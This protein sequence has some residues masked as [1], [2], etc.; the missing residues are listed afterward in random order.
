MTTKTKQLT[1][2]VTFHI[3]PTHIEAWKEAHRPVWDLCAQEP[4]CLFF[5]VF[6]DGSRPGRFRLV[7]VWSKDREWFESVQLKK[8]YYDDLWKRSQPTWEKEMEIEFWERLGEGCSF[9]EGYLKGG[10]LAE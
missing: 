9:K 2:F 7:E 6:E 5:D 1:L 3:K 10:I 8:A 4:E